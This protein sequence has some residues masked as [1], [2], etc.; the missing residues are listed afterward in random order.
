MFEPNWGEQL[1]DVELPV[2]VVLQL[3]TEECTV[4][5]VSK[6]GDVSGVLVWGL[7]QTYTFCAR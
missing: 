4:V 5:D 3:D 7:C 1:T 6:A 2:P